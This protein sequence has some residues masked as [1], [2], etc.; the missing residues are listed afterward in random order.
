MEV[1]IRE[2]APSDKKGR[3]RKTQMRPHKDGNNICKAWLKIP[4]RIVGERDH[5][6]TCAQLRAAIGDN[7]IPVTLDGHKHKG[8]QA[9]A[10]RAPP[11]NQ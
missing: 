5:A 11:S 8:P 1:H 6:I 7:N 3:T 10:S 9:A 2:M 4:A